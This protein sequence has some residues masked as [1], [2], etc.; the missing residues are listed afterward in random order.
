MRIYIF[1]RKEMILGAPEIMTKRTQIAPPGIA[2][3]E[4]TSPDRGNPV[5][6]NLYGFD[7]SGC[8]NRRD[9]NLLTASSG[10]PSD[11][12]T[13]KPTERKVKYDETNP[14]LP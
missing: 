2:A 8:R 4:D 7:Y 10:L 6:Q 5:G 3:H 11:R 13:T 14:F 9:F 1:N 12:I